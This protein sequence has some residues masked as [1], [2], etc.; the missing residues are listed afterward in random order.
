MIFDNPEYLKRVKETTEK[1]TVWTSNP[2][3]NSPTSIIIHIPIKTGDNWYMRGSLI[4]PEGT[5]DGVFESNKPLSEEYLRKI[6]LNGDSILD[7][8]LPD[9]KEF[10]FVNFGDENEPSMRFHL[11]GKDPLNEFI[12]YLPKDLGLKFTKAGTFSILS[13]I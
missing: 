11:S 12:L 3:V 1:F 8:K 5:N 9:D 6:M 7:K 10:G 2:E 4:F 13:R